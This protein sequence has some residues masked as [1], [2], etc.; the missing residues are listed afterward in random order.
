M[1]IC[2]HTVN[3][4]SCVK[5]V[6]IGTPDSGSTGLIFGVCLLLLWSPVGSFWTHAIVEERSFLSSILCRF[7]LPPVS[8]EGYPATPSSFPTPRQLT[9]GISSGDP[10]VW[11]YVEFWTLVESAATF[12]EMIK[13]VQQWSL[14]P[15]GGNC[16]LR[17][18]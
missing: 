3:V 2:I 9:E 6:W 11:L 16:S 15:T 17:L 4:W 18:N 13:V 10:P 7:L 5:H 14:Q 8:L 1:R 12:L